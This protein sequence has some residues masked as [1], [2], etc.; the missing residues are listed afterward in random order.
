MANSENLDLKRLDEPKASTNFNHQ[1]YYQNNFDKIDAAMGAPPSTLTTEAKTLVPAIIELQ[2]DKVDKETGKGLSTNDFDNTYK[3]K[4]DTDIPAQL[5]EKVQNFKIKN[6]VVNGDFNTN[7]SGWIAENTSIS[8]ISGKMNIIGNGS[9]VL[10]R[11]RQE[12]IKKP[13]IGTK[14]YIRAT[15]KVTNS[16]AARLNLILREGLAGTVFAEPIITSPLI[17]VEYVLSAIGSININLINPLSLIVNHQYASAGVS[18][19]KI[20]EV[21]K[22]LFVDLTNIFG[23]GNEPTKLE[24]DELMKVIPNGWWDGE[25]SLTQKQYVIWKLNLWRKTTNAVIALG[26]TIV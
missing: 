13:T 11:A 19:G 15:C 16:E 20:M 10:C 22:V 12:N 6:E 2:S 1:I 5:E 3:Q 24:M 4:I 9:S 18:T 26:G 14:I 8:T 23:T 7:T 25:L 21:D 17:S